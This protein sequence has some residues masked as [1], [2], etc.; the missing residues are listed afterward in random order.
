ML[1]AGREYPGQRQ[2]GARFGLLVLTAVNMLNYADRYVPSAG[3]PFLP[4]I[5][6]LI[7]SCIMI[8]FTVKELI[9]DDLDL[10]DVET[11]Y[12]TTGMIFLYMIFAVVFGWIGDR[13]LADRR[14]ILAGAILFW[15]LATALAGLAQ[16]L[17]QLVI[18][19]S[20]VGVGEAAYSTIAPPMLSD[21]YPH[22][23][24]NIA[25]GIYYLAIPV[26]GALGFA[27]GSLLGG[28]FGWRVAFLGVGMPGILMSVLILLVNDPSCGINDAPQ[29]EGRHSEIHHNTHGMFSDTVVWCP[30]Y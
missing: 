23:D 8:Y 5:I 24:R 29:K 13:R 11:T 6:L 16:N 21:F 4:S 25:F 1:C 9:K 28:A 17:A 14:Y 20:L 10:S 12:P 15:S 30:H 18:L 27:I 2:D 3:P 7:I 26:G 22:K 19:R